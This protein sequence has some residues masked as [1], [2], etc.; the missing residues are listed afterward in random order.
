MGMDVPLYE[1]S[2]WLNPL[3]NDIN[4]SL[5]IGYN[6]CATGSRADDDS[7]G[8]KTSTPGGVGAR[9]SIQQSK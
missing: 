7:R 3:L 1:P 9:I 2:K 6:V 4:G 8:V 5:F